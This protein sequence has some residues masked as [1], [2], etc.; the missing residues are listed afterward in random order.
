MDVNFPIST[1]QNLKKCAFFHDSWTFKVQC[2]PHINHNL[3]SVSNL[4]W[5]VEKENMINAY[6][7]NTLLNRI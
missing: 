5:K 4:K 7:D 3:N 6:R 1:K 2:F